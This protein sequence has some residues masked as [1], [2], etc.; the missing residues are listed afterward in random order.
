MCALHP[1]EE[2][3]CILLLIFPP[4]ELKSRNSPGALD[5]PRES[6]MERVISGGELLPRLCS[7]AALVSQNTRLGDQASEELHELR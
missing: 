5:V 3:I 7:V 4:A 6:A 2:S 1:E